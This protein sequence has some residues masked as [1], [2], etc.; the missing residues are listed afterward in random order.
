MDNGKIVEEGTHKL[1]SHNP[2]SLYSHFWKLQVK[3]D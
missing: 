2:K 1:L 3:N